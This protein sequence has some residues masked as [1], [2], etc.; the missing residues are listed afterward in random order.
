[1]YYMIGKKSIS[2]YKSGVNMRVMV[3][4]DYNRC[5]NEEGLSKY[6]SDDKKFIVS[7]DEYY[8][9]LKENGDFLGMKNLKVGGE[10]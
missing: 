6:L 1:M 7:E 2:E 5:V 8:V 4:E 3:W 10:L 9:Y